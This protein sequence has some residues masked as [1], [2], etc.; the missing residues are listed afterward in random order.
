MADSERGLASQG[1]PAHLAGIFQSLVAAA[2][3]GGLIPVI[4]RGWELFAHRPL[5]AS[6]QTPL[7]DV[8]AAL[9]LIP[10]FWLS[11][12]LLTQL[13]VHRTGATRPSINAS[14]SVGSIGTRLA[15]TG[16]AFLVGLGINYFFLGG[17][18]AVF[19]G[20]CGLVIL[21]GLLDEFDAVDGVAHVW[22]NLSNGRMYSIWLGAFVAIPPFSL[23]IFAAVFGLLLA[24]CWIIVFLMTGHFPR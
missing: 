12:R 18:G 21:C 2:L 4:N 20:V 11:T 19:F 22:A 15:A 23:A 14:Y 7:A 17:W 3:G 13:S 24:I 1:A 8:V 5:S 9:L 16:C 10:A 6:A